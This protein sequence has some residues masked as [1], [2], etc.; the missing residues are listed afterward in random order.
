[1]NRSVTSNTDVIYHTISFWDPVVFSENA[2]L[3][4]WGTLYFAMKNVSDDS[5]Y[6]SFLIVTGLG[7]QRH[8]LSRRYG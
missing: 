7:G 3:L 2:Y 4:G 5:L 6:I 1:M 8:L